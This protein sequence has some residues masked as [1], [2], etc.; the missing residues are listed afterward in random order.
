MKSM[1]QALALLLCFLMLFT[2]PVNAFATGADE[3]GIAPIS[4]T[5]EDYPQYNADIEKLATFNAAYTF[6]D[7][8]MCDSEPLSLSDSLYPYK[9][10]FSSDVVFEI[11]GYKVLTEMLGEVEGSVATVS[12]WYSVKIYSGTGPENLLDGFW[13]YQNDLSTDTYPNV[14][15]L[16][17]RTE[18]I[19][20]D[21]TVSGAGIPE[22]SVFSA[23]DVVDE[24]ELDA[25]FGNIGEAL[26]PDAP[27]ED[28]YL[29]LNRPCRVL[30]LSFI[31]DGEE[32][33]PN[34][35][36]QVTVPVGDLGIA[37]GSLCNIYHLHDDRTLDVLYAIVENG[38][39]TFTVDSFSIVALAGNNGEIYDVN[40]FYN[41]SSENISGNGQFYAAGVYFTDSG[42]A[43]VLIGGNFNTKQANKIEKVYLDDNLILSMDKNTF[44]TYIDAIADMGSLV[45]YDGTTAAS[46][47]VYAYDVASGTDWLDI[48]LGNQVEIGEYFEISIKTSTG[49]GQ[50]GTA[51]NL[52]I[53]VIAHLE[54]DIVKTVHTV[55]DSVYDTKSAPGVT[56]KDVIFKIEAINSGDAD[57]LGARIEELLPDGIFDI[58]SV[59]YSTDLVN[60]TDGEKSSFTIQLGDLLAGQT[61]TYYVKARILNTNI[62]DGSYTNI[63]HL[64]SDSQDISA[65]DDASITM[66]SSFNI[67]KSVYS[68]NGN[69]PQAAGSADASTSARV[70][71]GDTVIYKI[72][73][74][75][76]SENTL[77]NVTITDM[78]PRG[79]YTGTVYYGETDTPS[80]AATISMGRFTIA[81]NISIPAHDCAV[82][83]VKLVVPNDVVSGTYANNAYMSV[84]VGSTEVI[85]QDS[86]NIVVP[87]ILDQS[88][89]KSVHMVNDD[90]VN[91]N[92]VPTVSLGD[93]VIYEIK[94]SND[95]NTALQ[96]TYIV[97]RIPECMLTS[98]AYYSTDGAEWSQLVVTDGT[99]RFGV[100]ENLNDSYVMLHDSSFT[101]YVKLTIDASHTAGGIY[102]NT[103][104]LYA[105][106]EL[107]QDS[108]AVQLNVYTSL[109]ITKTG[110]QMNLDENQSF[111]F[112]VVGPNEFN[113]TVTIKGN[114]SVTIKDVPF[115]KYTVTE[116][117][118]WSWRYDPVSVSITKDLSSDPAENHF[119]FTNT[120]KWIYWLSGDCY[121][122]NWWGGDGGKVV[123]KDED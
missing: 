76:E 86:A 70:A 24:T 30:D 111:I 60:W 95:G 52:G 10:D 113:I 81:S 92:D 118:D 97:D 47:V 13:I 117:T 3:G 37:D 100:G 62:P 114:D 98:E 88:I 121:C 107:C 65:E 105:D 43:H 34:G 11:T 21:V 41:V 82:Y 110:A 109:T 120:R 83:Y 84:F 67:G 20:S 6:P 22:G 1:K 45:L 4:D 102:T 85:L 72:T 93:T 9:S 48:N 25:V 116:K 56:G 55:G 36:V 91:G 17:E 74:N 69:V 33:Q 78:L 77:S 51:F 75:N 58:T 106:T 80:T 46:D 108:A 104:I 44:S 66:S 29:V 57:I 49:G 2:S 16:T 73:V 23:V 71:A 35:A 122:E 123:R 68:V 103:A 42:E 101:Y 26:F 90:V 18:V 115:G 38:S 12:L 61:K 53:Y 89:S 99:L 39:T 94:V 64:E 54:Y 112:D 63:V 28:R 87:V 79:A 119:D 19:P 15:T 14:L 40:T 31:R 32:V 27:A 50:E 8:I 5:T 96:N 59:A 7:F